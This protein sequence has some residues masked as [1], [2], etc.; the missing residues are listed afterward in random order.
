MHTSNN[1]HRKLKIMKMP[2]CIYA[3]VRRNG[4]AMIRHCAIPIK[5]TFC[6]STYNVDVIYANSS[7]IMPGL[8]YG[9][10]CQTDVLMYWDRECYC[11]TTY[12][13]SNSVFCCKLGG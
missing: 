4:D 7:S 8:G 6:L 12:Y 9:I 2:S 1:L 11:M 3:V 5:N 10:I 13:I